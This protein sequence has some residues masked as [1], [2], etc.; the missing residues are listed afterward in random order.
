MAGMMA[1]LDKTSVRVQVEKLKSDFEQLR[2]DGKVTVEIQAIMG[3]MLM[4]VELILAI[5]LE[6][7]TKKNSGNSSI[8]PS[9]TDK[10]NSSLTDTGSNDK[11]KKTGGDKVNNRRTLETVTVAPVLFCD[12]CGT[13]LEQVAY[14]IERRTKIDIVFEKVVEHVDAE[15]KRCPSCGR[16]VKGK[17]PA[18]M[19]GPLQY[20]LGVQAFAINLLACQMVALR[21]A[22]ALV[23]AII[24]V[25]ISEATLLQFI[26]RL[27]AALENW[28]VQATQKLL[29]EAVMHVDETSLRVEKKNYWIHVHSGGGITLKKLHRKRGKLA[30]EENNIIPRFRGKLIH[31]CL[32]SYFS[33][34]HCGHGLCGS[35]LLRELA[36]VV[37]SN[38]FRWAARMKRLLQGACKRV[39]ERQE[40]C[41]DDKEYARL[42][43]CYQ[44]ILEQGV[45]EMPPI[46]D[47]PEGK[48]GKIAKSDAHNLLE[49]LQKHE[50]SVLLFA[51]DPLVPFT[52]NRGER[53]LR[54]SKVKQKVSGCFRS[55]VY[56]HA[57][58]RITSYLQTMAYKGINPMIAI[59]MALAGEIGGE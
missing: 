52:N 4:I 38:R 51:K 30:M 22:Q 23:Y 7:T 19:P 11:G 36:F 27:H 18:D 25:V 15:I 58:C 1:S 53:D 35:H 5:F 56:A 55:E 9:Q 48:R 17:F 44:K 32:A 3:S 59:Q 40:K 28:E 34:T 10:D 41:L 47:K 2:L 37:E 46:P 33:Y 49:R 20:G 45:S 57:Y 42:Q 24:D 43:K 16:T 50:A 54:M 21:R 6:R 29:R 8:P 13:D 12:V 31:D 14:T 26:L 39:S